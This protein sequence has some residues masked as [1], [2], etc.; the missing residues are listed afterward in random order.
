EEEEEEGEKAPAT[1]PTLCSTRRLA[2]S[3]R[4]ASSFPMLQDP[5]RS[6]S[7]LERTSSSVSSQTKA[8][9]CSNITEDSTCCSQASG[10]SPAQEKGQRL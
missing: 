8:S 2:R 1:N 9:S 3:C 6:I 4:G 5:A 10:D 7:P